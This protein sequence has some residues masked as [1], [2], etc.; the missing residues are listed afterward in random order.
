MLSGL[1]L[2]QLGLR[3][4][5]LAAERARIVRDFALG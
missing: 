5:E 3:D 2:T 4:S 1:A